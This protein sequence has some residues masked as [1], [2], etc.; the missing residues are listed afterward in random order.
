[1]YKIYYVTIVAHVSA[2]VNSMI[3]SFKSIQVGEVGQDY[4]LST[5]NLSTNFNSCTIQ[6]IS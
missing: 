6:Y 3:Q 2:L 5:R 4:T 1:M